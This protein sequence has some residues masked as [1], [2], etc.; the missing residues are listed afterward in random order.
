MFVSDFEWYMSEIYEGK[1]IMNGFLEN[2]VEKG[3]LHNFYFF[4]MIGIDKLNEVDYRKAFKLFVAD[5]AGIHF[6]GNSGANRIFK[7]DSISYKEQAKI[8]KAGIGLAPTELGDR[9]DK[10]IVPLARR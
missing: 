10:V 1:K 8:Y 7:F 3:K 9:V 4:G 5:K 6:G 2:I